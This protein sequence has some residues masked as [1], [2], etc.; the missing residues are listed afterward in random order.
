M[1][2][3]DK[4][5]IRY[6][7]T[8]PFPIYV[9]FTVDPVAFAKEL[10]RLKVTKPTPFVNGGAGGTTHILTKDGTVTCIVCVTIPKGVSREEMAG[11]LVHEAVHCWQQT[12]E[13][14]REDEPSCEFEAY[15]I[16]YYA[17]AFMSELA[18]IQKAKRGQK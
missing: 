12:K 6:F 3:K 4:P 18:R 7:H 8:G 11:L 9:G 13:A 15:T 1:T 16:Q 5:C 17:Q 14:M 10:K 2:A